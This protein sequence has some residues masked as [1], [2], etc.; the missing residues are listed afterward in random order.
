MTMKGAD[1]LVFPHHKDDDDLEYSCWTRDGGP[2]K[3]LDLMI[4]A[5]QVIQD[6]YDS[7]HSVAYQLDR[8]RDWNAKRPRGTPA[9]RV[10]YSR[11]PSP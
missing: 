11:A 1:D 7:L 4:E 6:K 3:S 9:V 10:R 5:V 2:V 8:S